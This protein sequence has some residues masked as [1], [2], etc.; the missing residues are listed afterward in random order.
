MADDPKGDSMSAS[1]HTPSPP[2]S[3]RLRRPRAATAALAAAAALA[4]LCPLGYALPS[5]AAASS[6]ASASAGAQASSASLT[7]LDEHGRAVD[8]LGQLTLQ[9]LATALH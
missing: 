6:D 3:P 8:V 7:V 5:S 1:G 2:H 9:Q 4:C